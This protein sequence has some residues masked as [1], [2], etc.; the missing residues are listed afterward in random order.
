MT[1]NIFRDWI[2]YF[3]NFLALL[4]ILALSYIYLRSIKL[5]L[6][7]LNLERLIKS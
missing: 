1:E 7:W 4:S 2:F 3:Y 6:V 5:S